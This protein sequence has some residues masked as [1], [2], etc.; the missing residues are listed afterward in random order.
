MP[1]RLNPG[2][3]PY[4]SEGPQPQPQ[5]ESEPNPFDILSRQQ[6]GEGER[7]HEELVAS[8]R[9]SLVA[10]IEAMKPVEK[11]DPV[12][13]MREVFLHAHGNLVRKY[14]PELLGKPIWEM[15][16]AQLYMAWNLIAQPYYK[17]ARTRRLGEAELKLDAEHL[18]HTI[19]LD[20]NEGKLL[21]AMAEAV[22]IPN[23]FGPVTPEK[24]EPK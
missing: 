17:S 19:T 3:G 16:Y 14:C 20:P 10:Y 2:P 24:Q 7:S 4:H 8:I 11:Y 15:P 18:G 5:R 1:E 21:S 9:Q 6:R 22:G 12:D 13:A 23:P